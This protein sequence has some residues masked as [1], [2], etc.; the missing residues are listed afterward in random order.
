MYP[1]VRVPESAFRLLRGEDDWQ[2]YHVTEE[3]TNATQAFSF[4]RNCAVHLV[5][6]IDTDPFMV[7]FNV[8]CL[9]TP[10]KKA[11]TRSLG[12][13]ALRRGNRT[14]KRTLPASSPSTRSKVT[15]EG[16]GTPN[17]R[18]LSPPPSPI[19]FDSRLTDSPTPPPEE[20]KLSVDEVVNAERALP[21]FGKEQSL[22]VTSDTFNSGGHKPKPYALK[23][24]L[25]NPRFQTSA[26]VTE[27]PTDTTAD[28]SS[29]IYAD[30]ENSL[31]GSSVASTKGSPLPP[32]VGGTPRSA[33]ISSDYA[34]REK[35]RS[36]LSKHMKSAN[37]A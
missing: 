15:S 21:F 3:R 12:L 20:D 35:L 33:G 16:P 19:S 22:S 7:S 10:W 5:H 30:D 13:P 9:T 31:Y 27:W 1:S 6:A 25:P 14:K 4:C 26:S 2:T 23:R 29:D 18:G 34:L 24:E 36:R 32:T 28:T 17:S 8:H 11:K 37:S